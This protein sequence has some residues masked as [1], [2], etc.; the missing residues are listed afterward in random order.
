LDATGYKAN[1]LV[2]SAVERQFEIIGE[3]LNRLSQ[4]DPEVA[5][6]V[7]DLP[8]IVSFRNVLI[9]GYATIDHARVWEITSDSIPMLQE[10]VTALL[11]ELG[12]PDT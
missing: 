7:P 11:A 5:A 8:E 1:A 10:T 6:R 9:H 2:R 4:V 12:P 3:A